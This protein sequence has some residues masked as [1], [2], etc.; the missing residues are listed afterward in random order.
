MKLD[1]KIEAAEPAGDTRIDYYNAGETWAQDTHRSLRASRRVAWIAAGVLAGVAAAQALALA[2]L[3]PLKTVV[4]YTILVDRQNGSAEL[5]RGVKLGPLAEDQALTQSF[6][7]Q[8]VL[9]RETFDAADLKYAY[10]RVLLWSA[11]E[12]RAAYLKSFD[13]N[14]PNS[15]LRQIPQTTVVSTVVRSVSL[16]SRTSALVRFDTQR[17]DQSGEQG[18]RTP[19]VAVIS[20]HYSGAP[21]KPNDRYLNPLGF[22]VLKYRRDVE[23][24]VPEAPALRAAG[25]GPS[26]ATGSEPSSLDASSPAAEPPGAAR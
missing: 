21:M 13:R 25:S 8:Y 20:F 5:M 23:A 12:A 11:D 9:A 17:T 2:A 16:L 14:D 7:V 24:P 15:T 26:E 3:A 18:P 19:M 22:Q 10:K 1:K 4:P 6:L